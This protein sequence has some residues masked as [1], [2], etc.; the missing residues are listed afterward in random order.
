MSLVILIVVVLFGCSLNS[1][2]N[3]ES[4]IKKN[5]IYS[6]DGRLVGYTIERR[7]GQIVYYSAD[8]KRVGY[9]LEFWD[10]NI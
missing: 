7:S 10:D 4:S 2:V 1:N 5:N 6:S 8:G 9:S 3:S